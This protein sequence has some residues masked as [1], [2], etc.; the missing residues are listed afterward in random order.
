[1]SQIDAI[2][3][4]V[5]W[6]ETGRIVDPASKLPYATHSGVF[7]FGDEPIKCYRLNTGEAV[8]DADDFKRVFGFLF[9]GIA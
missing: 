9:E 6:E 5:A 2:L 7:M 3:R 1:M 4:D 8:F